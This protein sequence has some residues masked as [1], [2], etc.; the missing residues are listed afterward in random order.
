M[1]KMTHKAEANRL[2]SARLI[3]SNSLEPPSMAQLLAPFGYDTPRIKEGETLLNT[4]EQLIARHNKEYGDQYAATEALNKQYAEARAFYMEHVK[5]ARVAQKKHPSMDGSL[6]LQGQRK[7]TISGWL[8]QARIFYENALGIVEIK[9]ALN[10][11]GVDKDALVSGMERVNAVDVA[12]SAQK[13]KI[14]VAQTTTKEKDRVMDALD[15]W[16]S[17]FK[18]VARVALKDDSQLLE[19]FGIVTPS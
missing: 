1:K 5:L 14:S 19:A 15:E 3:I 17:E 11:Y 7:R 12:L 13:R 2:V 9:E 10:A 16:V 18:S 8:V 4:A 6:Q